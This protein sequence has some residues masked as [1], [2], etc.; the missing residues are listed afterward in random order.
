MAT[1]GLARGQGAPTKY[2]G[3]HGYSQRAKI[4][5]LTGLQSNTTLQTVTAIRN[6]GFGEDII[7]LTINDPVLRRQAETIKII[8][9]DTNE[10]MLISV[11]GR[12][13]IIVH[14]E[15]NMTPKRAEMILYD[16]NQIE[17]KRQSFFN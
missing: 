12:E 4:T 7:C 16:R 14:R 13:N 1:D 10:E 2:G 5:Y 6:D 8:F 17:L 9:F 3:L 11:Q 15:L